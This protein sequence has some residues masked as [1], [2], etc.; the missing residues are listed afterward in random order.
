MDR[1]PS[2]AIVPAFL[3]VALAG[4]SDEPAGGGA[5]IARVNAVRAPASSAPPESWCEV[6][7][8]AADA[9]RFELPPLAADASGQGFPAQAPGR[10]VWLNLWATWCAPCIREMPVLARW[11]GELARD[12]AKVDF[13]F[14]TLD[15]DLSELGRFLRENPGTPPGRQL[16]VSSVDV[17]EPWFVKYKLAASTAIPVQVLVAPGGKVRCLRVGGLNEADYRLVRGLFDSP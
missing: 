8:G 14:L 11:K 17:M 2:V 7:F 13:W 15:E 10:W 9:P 4:C 6:A 3:L 16:R 5:A 1:L 12:G